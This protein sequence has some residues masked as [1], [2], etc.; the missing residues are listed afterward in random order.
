MPRKKH[1][2]VDILEANRGKYRLD[3]RDTKPL[4]HQLKEIIKL[5]IN[6]KIWTF[7][8]LIPSE[9]ELSAIYDVSV[10]TV[11]KALSVLVEEGILY[12]RQGRGTYVSRPNFRNSFIRFFRYGVKNGDQSQIPTSRVISSEIIKSAKRTREILGLN[13]NDKVIDI[14]RVR[15]LENTPLMFEHLY[16][17]QR[18][19]KGFDHIDISQQLLYPIYDEKY[20][21]PIIWAD[22]YLW[23]DIVDKET[24]AY[25]EIQAG[26]PIICI[27]RIAYTTGD[28]PVEYRMSIGRGDHFRYHIELR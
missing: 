2:K 20:N 8:E 4:Y 13:T 17:P 16:L 3:H 1:S 23:P 18:V 21:T 15:Y 25:L 11:K 14:K 22:E 24:A 6:D 19:F 28:Q 7:D 12:R 5:Q 26:D 27:E 9:N 10:G